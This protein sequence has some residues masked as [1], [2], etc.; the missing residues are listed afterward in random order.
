[1]FLTLQYYHFCRLKIIDQFSTFSH[2]GTNEKLSI[3]HIFS[4]ANHQP[5][6]NHRAK[7]ATIAK[8]RFT[9]PR[10]YAYSYW[11]FWQNFIC[12]LII[13]AKWRQPINK[14]NHNQ[15]LLKTTPFIDWNSF[16]SRNKDL[17]LTFSNE[18][19]AAATPFKL[20]DHSL[21]VDFFNSRSNGKCHRV[22]R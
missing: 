3:G 7:S 17:G 10:E 8:Q 18:M 19:H 4:S 15:N 13:N 21:W 9:A 1:M 22:A 12:R 16:R 11:Q 5:S 2:V 20:F 14:Q 6:L